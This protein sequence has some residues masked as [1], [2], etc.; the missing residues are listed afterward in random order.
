MLKSTIWLYLCRP[1]PHFALI[2]VK[3]AEEPWG[4]GLPGQGLPTIL[5]KCLISAYQLIM[6]S[7]PIRCF[8]HTLDNV[9]NH[10]VIPTLLEC[11]S[12][13]IRLFRHS[14]KAKLLWKDLTGQRPRSYS[15]TRW[16]SKWEVY[17]QILMQLGDIERFLIEAEATYVSLQLLPQLQAIFSDP[18]QLINLK[19]ELAISID[20][21]EHFVKATYFLEGDSTAFFPYGIEINRKSTCSFH[22][23]VWIL[24]GKALHK[25]YHL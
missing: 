16:W 24:T 10:L 21:G 18:E 7:R 22:N 2:L 1:K 8:S 17:Q 6:E 12:V 25:I 3:G 5:H 20:V 11:G 13:W 14:Y 15:E 23:L 19:L 9:G 4:I